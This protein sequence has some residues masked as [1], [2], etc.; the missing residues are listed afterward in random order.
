MMSLNRNQVKLIKQLTNH[1]HTNYGISKVD[2]LGV[3]TYD[4]G[5]LRSMQ[6]EDRDKRRHNHISSMASQLMDNDEGKYQLS[7]IQ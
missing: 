6:L 3:V 1:I 4:R 5:H 7:L 2:A